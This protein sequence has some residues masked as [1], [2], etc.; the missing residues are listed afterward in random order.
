M[1]KDYT[2]AKAVAKEVYDYYIREGLFAVGLLENT[3]PPVL[4]VYG[5]K[6]TVKITFEPKEG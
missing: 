5:I 6:D 3:E 4:E 2:M 1:N